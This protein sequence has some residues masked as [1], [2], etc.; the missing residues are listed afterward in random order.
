VVPGPDAPWTP[1]RTTAHRL[2]RAA[3][4]GAGGLLIVAGALVDRL[5]V[6]PLLRVD[7]RMSGAYWVVARKQAAAPAG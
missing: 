7:P 5:V 2:G 4:L 6:T 3:G 1:P